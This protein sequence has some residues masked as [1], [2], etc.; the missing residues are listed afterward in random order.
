M[1]RVDDLEMNEKKRIEKFSN[2]FWNLKTFEKWTI[3]I[4]NFKS[5]FSK[6]KKKLP[7]RSTNFGKLLT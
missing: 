6:K 3:W 4:L 2:D 7:I 5:F 1:F